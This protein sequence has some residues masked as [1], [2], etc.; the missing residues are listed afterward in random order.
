M[1][2]KTTFFFS[3][4]VIFIQNSIAYSQ[5]VQT[6]SF[7]ITSTTEAILGK[8]T[9][10]S[11]KKILDL[12]EEIKWSVYVPKTYNP[13]NPPGIL[14]YQLYGRGT[15]DPTGWPTAMDDRNMILIRIIGK[16]GEYP[17]R[18]ELIISIL[19]PLVL[20]QRYKIDTNRIYTSSVRGCVNAGAIAMNYP[21][22]VKGAIYINC[23][24]G[25]WRKKEPELIELMRQ[26]RYY[27]VAGRDRFKQI[28]NRQEIRRYKDAGIKNVKFVR[29]G[30][31]DH[32]KNLNRFQLVDAIDYLDG[33]DND[34][35]EG[36]EN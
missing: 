33:N 4:I 25:T 20:Q 14:L 17:L 26:N 2:L 36:D 24:P 35:I 15:E 9:A 11:Y 12:D 1:F 3:I 27:F 13:S 19:A 31:L 6:G 5:E 34:N 22:I 18:K 16:G 23:N 7:I 8:E 10:E 28:D 21:N 29:M 30:N 32:L